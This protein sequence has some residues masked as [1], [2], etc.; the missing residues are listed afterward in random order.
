VLISLFVVPI[1]VI[2]LSLPEAG[3]NPDL[4][5]LTVP[6]GLGR[7]G[8]ALLVFLG[9]FSAATSMVI[10]AALALSTMVSNHIIVPLWLRRRGN[11]DPMSGDMR[12]VCADGAAAVHRRHPVSGA[13]LLPPVGRGRCAGRDRADRVPGRGAGAAGASGR[14]PVAR[15]DAGG[16]GHRHR[17]GLRDLGVAPVDPNI[18]ETGGLVPPVL[19]AGPF[20]LM[21]LSPATPLGLQATD[22]L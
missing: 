18:A 10:V 11:E 17:C 16:G 15:G 9:G 20:G 6:L 22:P 2:G 19:D 5:V 1:A 7:D 12:R 21:W 13:G 8:L 3:A 14:H 4:F